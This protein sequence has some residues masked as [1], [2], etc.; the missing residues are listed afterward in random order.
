[1]SFFHAYQAYEHQRE[2]G[3]FGPYP[4]EGRSSQ[5]LVLHLL[6]EIGEGLI[7][8]GSYLKTRPWIHPSTGSM[9]TLRRLNP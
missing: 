4:K 3:A 6:D 5:E 9:S 7:R 1:M 2:I 8:A